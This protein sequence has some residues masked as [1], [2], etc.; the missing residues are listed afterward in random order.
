MKRVASSRMMDLSR[1]VS[2]GCI[3]RP[4][5]VSLPSPARP[6]ARSRGGR[7]YAPALGGVPGRA[8]K[9][10][11][12]SSPARGAPGPPWPDMGRSLSFASSD[13][14]PECHR[15]G[16]VG[17]AP[18]TTKAASVAAPSRSGTVRPGGAT[19]H[20]G[21]RRATPDAGVRWAAW[22]GWAVRRL[23][24]IGPEG[25]GGCLGAGFCSGSPRAML[26]RDAVSSRAAPG[27]G[28]AWRAARRHIPAPGRGKAAGRGAS[29]GEARRGDRGGLPSAPAGGMGAATA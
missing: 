5:R 18:R 19:L 25:R 2:A 10:G 1:A 8:V 13:A 11:R 28:S 26:W 14:G 23:G 12:V 4:V 27:R 17:H 24:G 21:A 9:P 29:S 7:G 6:W 22:E 3:T 20:R 15:C 16:P